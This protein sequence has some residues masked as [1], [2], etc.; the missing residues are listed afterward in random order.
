MFETSKILTIY[1]DKEGGHVSNFKKLLKK[2]PGLKG[3]L[4]TNLLH[5]DPT[6]DMGKVV[7]PKIEAGGVPEQNINAKQGS[8]TQSK[9]ARLKAHFPTIPP[10]YKR[11]QSVKVT[12][13]T[14]PSGVVSTSRLRPVPQ[15]E[16]V[17]IKNSPLATAVKKKS[18]KDKLLH[19][20]KSPW[21]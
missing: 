19:I 10:R 4:R 17:S 18:L 2:H 3:V 13:V 14:T 15:A 20:V 11:R 5:G 12:A 1:A 9:W 21:Q 16:N 8:Q 7:R 6:P